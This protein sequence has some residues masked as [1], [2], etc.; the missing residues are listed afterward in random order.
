MD[1]PGL[2]IPAATYQVTLLDC[3]ELHSRAEL[4]NAGLRK[5]N[6]NC[7]WLHDKWRLGIISD[8]FIYYYQAVI[9]KRNTVG[10]YSYVLQHN[11][12]EQLQKYY[13]NLLAIQ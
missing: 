8:P 4:G 3:T 6:I 12:Y 5:T 2:R 11:T 1:N 13:L 9:S 7:T 10:S